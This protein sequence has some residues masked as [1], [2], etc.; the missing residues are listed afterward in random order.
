MKSERPGVARWNRWWPHGVITA[1]TKIAVISAE[2]TAEI[3]R[4]FGL[5]HISSISRKTASA[6]IIVTASVPT[7]AS[8]RPSESTATT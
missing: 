7:C 5:R 8:G 3:A 4:V 1:N 2:L 6:A